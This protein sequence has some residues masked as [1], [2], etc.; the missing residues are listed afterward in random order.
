MEEVEGMVDNG[1]K[2]VESSKEYCNVI[3]DSELIDEEKKKHKKH[4]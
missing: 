3:D 4:T 1:P 2:G